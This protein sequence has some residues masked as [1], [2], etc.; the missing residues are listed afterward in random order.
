METINANVNSADCI[1][2]RSNFTNTEYVNICTGTHQKVPIGSLNM[3][4]TIA[5]FVMI[6]LAVVVITS[7]MI[8]LS[9]N[10]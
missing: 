6:V 2:E 3:F 5:L 9:R 10:R 1:K 8:G 4:G 7:L